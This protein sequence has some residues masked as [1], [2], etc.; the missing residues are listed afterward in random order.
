VAA[1]LRRAT[2]WD[3]LPNQVFTC[4]DLAIDFGSHKVV[5]GDC[6]L[7]LS[8]TEYKLLSHLTRNAGRVLTPD[9][10]LTAVWGDDYIGEYD[11]L[12]VNI[13]SVMSHL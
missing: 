5:L 2:T 10:L 3:E 1:V 7:N 9:Q 13:T 11:M 8:S 12:R 6:E 4:G